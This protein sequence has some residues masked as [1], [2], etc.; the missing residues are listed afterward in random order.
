MKTYPAIFKFRAKGTFPPTNKIT[1]EGTIRGE[2]E[3]HEGVK[4]HFPT[5]ETFRA[6]EVFVQEKNPTVTF[7]FDNGAVTLQLLKKKTKLL[8]EKL[9]AK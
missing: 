1:L 3:E 9:A 6:A 5:L 7:D 2:Y 8:Q 4:S